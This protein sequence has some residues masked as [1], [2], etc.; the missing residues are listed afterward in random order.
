MDRIKVAG[1][2]GV[3]SDKIMYLVG[4]GE[5]YFEVFDRQF[6]KGIGR[7]KVM[8]LSGKGDCALV[9]L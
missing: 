3:V 7:K 6:R 5:M 1:L 2:G 9:V 8:R 4:E